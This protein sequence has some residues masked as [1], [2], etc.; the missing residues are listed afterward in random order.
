MKQLNAVKFFVL[1]LCLAGQLSCRSTQQSPAKTVINEDTTAGVRGTNIVNLVVLAGGQPVKAVHLTVLN[2]KGAV[3]ANG[4]TN[5]SGEF[6]RDLVPGSY[7]VKV[8]WQGKTVE[9]V[10]QVVRANTQKVDL[11]INAPS[12]QL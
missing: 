6:F 1:A 3:V 11:D 4:T 8:D 9:H 5:E 10:V 2:G 7:K 12:G